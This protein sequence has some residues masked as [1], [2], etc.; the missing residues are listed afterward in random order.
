MS[1]LSACNNNSDF[2]S[3]IT[4]FVLACSIWVS[5]ANIYRALKGWLLSVFN[6]KLSLK[7]I[8]SV[9]SGSFCLMFQFAIISCNFLFPLCVLHSRGIREIHG[10]DCSR[11]SNVMR[12]RLPATR[13]SVM[14]AEGGELSASP[15]L[16]CVLIFITIEAQQK[17]LRISLFDFWNLAEVFLL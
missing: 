10:S 2:N 9:F 3:Y 15:S 6:G 17:S 12:C 8:N 7:W 4:Q 14:V 11:D 1:S 16:A 5:P 13:R